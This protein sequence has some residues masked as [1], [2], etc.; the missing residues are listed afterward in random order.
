MQSI[1]CLKLLLSEG[2]KPK[3][4][5]PVLVAV[6]FMR[7]DLRPLVGLKSNPRLNILLSKPWNRDAWLLVLLERSYYGNGSRFGPVLQTI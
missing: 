1:A 3:D 4:R 7:P 2:K 5:N 6:T